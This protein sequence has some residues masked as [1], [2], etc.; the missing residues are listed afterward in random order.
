MKVGVLGALVVGLAGSFRPP[1]ASRARA[2]PRAAEAPAVEAAAEAELKA[3]PLEQLKAAV[4]AGIG[5]DEFAVKL[6]KLPTAVDAI[7]AL[8]A[9]L[10]SEKPVLGTA[11]FAATLDMIADASAPPAACGALIGHT[12]ARLRKCS[13]RVATDEVIL[14]P[15]G[16]AL[17]RARKDREALS[18]CDALPPQFRLDPRALRTAII[19]AARLDDAARVREL[20]EAAL[21]QSDASEA[22]AK[23]RQQDR[24]LDD[25][26]VGDDDSKPA[27]RAAAKGM[28]TLDDATLKFAIK[29][30]AKAGDYRTPFAILSALPKDRRSTPLYHAAITACGKAKPSK[31]KTA[32]L[33]WRRMK[34]DSCDIPRATY[35]ALLH[36]A[37]SA[38]MGNATTAI[39]GEMAS[40]NVS[41]NVVSYNI[42]LNSLA[43]KG[44]FAEMLDLLTALESNRIIPTD[45][46]F[47]TAING[48]ARANN[49]AAAVELLKAQARLDIAPADAAFG[50]ALEACL[51]DPDGAASAAAANEIIDIMVR[52]SVSLARRGRIEALAREAVHRGVI[53]GARL[54][55]D[56]KLLGMVLRNRQMEV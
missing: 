19:A 36:A 50:A 3:S 24:D 25:D 34:A 21:R 16:A 41:L 51:R 7:R 33:L 26:A 35:N 14:L 55:R 29:V 1:A 28:A 17:L 32:M 12:M 44:R 6:R 43:V 20:T 15:L 30:L 2:W 42:A 48:A 13:A 31:G 4:T 49:S 37:Q 5:A 22:A 8:D 40:N 46:T 39:L 38:E 23:R 18:T 45:V 56:E 54:E 10:A 53:D 9:G 52:T 47:G 27:K 11:A